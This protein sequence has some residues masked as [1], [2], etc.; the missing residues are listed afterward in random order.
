M[1]LVLDVARC[2][3][4]CPVD[5]PIHSFIVK[6]G[7]KKLKEEI[8]KIRAGRGAI[9]DVEIRNV[10]G[11][12][13]LGEIPGV[14][15]V[16]GCANYPKGGL[17]VAEICREFASRRYIVVTS[18]CAAMSAGMYKDEEGKTLYE[19]YTGEFDS[20]LVSLT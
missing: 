4:A 5:L 11:P 6:A 14:V 1:I 2:E 9:Q 18:G 19:T 12:I 17:E 15:A 10:G 8:Y 3:H 13:V 16:V 20:W 7:E